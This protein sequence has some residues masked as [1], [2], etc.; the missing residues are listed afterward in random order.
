MMGMVCN[1]MV[2][3]YDNKT[4]K[5]ETAKADKPE[6]SHVI[7]DKEVNAKFNLAIFYRL[8]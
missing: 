5:G 2:Y 8:L 7:E 6:K 4:V 3:Y 1:P